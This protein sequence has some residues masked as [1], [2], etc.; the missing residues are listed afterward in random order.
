[1]IYQFQKN[2]LRGIH[3]DN[4]TW[5]LVSCLYGSFFLLVVNNDKS[6]INIK[7]VI[8]NFG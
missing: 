4:K 7:V 1:M 5:K 8:H 3:G 2:V 6:Q